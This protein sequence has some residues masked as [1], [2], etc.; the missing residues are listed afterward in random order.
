MAYLEGTMLC[1][2]RMCGRSMINRLGVSISR[3]AG[4]PGLLVP[5]SAMYGVIAR[6]INAGN[7]RLAMRYAAGELS[8]RIVSAGAPRISSCYVRAR[9]A[10]APGDSFGRTLT[11]RLGL[12]RNA[13]A[14]TCNAPRGGGLAAAGGSVDS[15]L[16]A[17]PHD[18]HGFGVT[19]AAPHR[20]HCTWAEVPSRGPRLVH[21]WTGLYFGARADALAAP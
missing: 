1:V 17:P 10:V 12:A 8:G 9:A 15:Y 6:S 5:T 16:L 3:V 19:K 18:S 4:R 21:D 7:A 11:M 14:Y 20:Y 2:T 13:A